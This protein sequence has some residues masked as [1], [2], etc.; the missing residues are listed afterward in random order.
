ME[1][2]NGISAD[3]PLFRG[4]S[5]DTLQAIVALLSKA[6][7]HYADDSTKEWGYAD[8]AKVEA[9]VKINQLKLTVRA[10]EALYRDKPQLVTFYDLLDAVLRDARK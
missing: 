8:A 3:A 6:S 5:P 10:I 9:V 7:Y 4:A 2:I 1:K